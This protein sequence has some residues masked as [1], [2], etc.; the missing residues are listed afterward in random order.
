MKCTL[1][2]YTDQFHPDPWYAAALLIFTKNTRVT[3]TPDGLDAVI[4]WSEEKKREE[5]EY[6]A[7]TIRSSWEFVDYIFLLGG[8]TRA[9]THQLVRSR[10][11]S[12]AQQTMQVLE[13]DASDVAPPKGT[14]YRGDSEP[15]KEMTRMWD[16][17]VSTISHGSRGL[18]RRG[19]TVEQARGLLPT[20]IKTNIVVKA[21]LRTLV[22]LFHSRISPRNL[23]EFRDACVSMRELVI[24][25]HPWASIFLE[26]TTDKILADLEDHINKAGAKLHDVDWTNKGFKLVDQIRRS[27]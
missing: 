11:A 18:I 16:Y 19:A 14:W 15:D 10:H 26:Q 3:M 17:V 4:D 23:G 2:N 22:E 12:F 13:I 6:M 27:S 7:N 24:G 20:N 8:V 21:N 1:L 9:F 5:L 25:V